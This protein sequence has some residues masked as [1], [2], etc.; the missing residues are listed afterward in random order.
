MQKEETEK[1]EKPQCYS[2]LGG[3]EVEAKKKSLQLDVG[4]LGV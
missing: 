1:T 4:N 3:R 2:E